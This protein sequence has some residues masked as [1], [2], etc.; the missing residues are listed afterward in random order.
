MK[1]LGTLR[2][3]RSGIW[4]MKAEPHV[5]MMAKRVFGRMP[6]VGS[7]FKIKHTEQNCFELAW[8]VDRYPLNVS[9]PGELQKAADAHRKRLESIERITGKKYEP[10]EF[11]LAEPARVYQAQGADLWLTV[12]GLLLADDV[13]LGK[14]LTSIAGMVSGEPLPVCV[15]TLANLPGQWKNEINRFAPDLYCHVI[16]TVAVYDLP[17]NKAGRLPDVL[18]SSYHKMVGWCDAIAAY[19]KGVVWDEV[20]ELRHKGTNKAVASKKVTEAVTYRIGLSAT[21]IYNF[22]GEIFNVMSNIRPGALG[23]YGEF[24]QEWCTGG[25]LK[26]PDAFGSWMRSENLMLRRT[27]KDVRR[28]LPKL[29][30]I[31]INVDSDPAAMEAVKGRAGE[32]ARM[33]LSEGGGQRGEAMQAA[34]EFDV[35]MRQVTGIA[36]APY[37]ATFVKMLLEQGTPVVLFGWHHAV[38][39]IWLEQLKAFNPQMYTGQQ[40]GKQKQAA[41]ETFINGK[42]DLFICSLRSGTG[43]DGLQKRCCTTVHGELDWSPGI[44]EQNIGRVDR[45]GQESPVTAFMLISDEG[46]DPLMCEVLGLKTDQIEGL[47]GREANNVLQRTDD[48]QTLKRLAANYLRQFDPIAFESVE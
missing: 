36:K 19:C 37:V 2:L 20:Q 25:S 46:S 28:E 31:V 42:S 48:G 22:G 23:T 3:A 13:G 14:T 27:K 26:D 40:T 32:L 41:V 24:Q 15:V 34:A 33:I 11:N 45:D 12:Q 44:I 5:A 35:L 47:R 6:K 18:I 9:H 38:Y 39:D 10:R 7:V 17:R 8:F 16:K 1:N 29:Q 30:K 4:T 21:P 43:L